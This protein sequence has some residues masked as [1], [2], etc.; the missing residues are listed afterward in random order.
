MAIF[1]CHSLSLNSGRPYIKST[2]K[3]SIPMSCALLMHDFASAEL[4]ALFIQIKSRSIKDCMPM[5]SL[6]IPIC[7]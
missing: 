5:L 2:L 6:L 7:T 1:S 4:C 3:F